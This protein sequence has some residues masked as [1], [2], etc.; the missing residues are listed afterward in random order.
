M[1]IY[2]RKYRWKVI[3]VL[4]ALL[5]VAA[6][7]IY[8]DNLAGKLAKEEKQK[9]AQIADV[10]HYIATATDI[11]DYG[12]FVELI[13]ANKTVPIISTDNDGNIMAW[14]N[15]D[16]VKATDKAYLNKKL[17]EMKNYAEP[18][19][20]EISE[21]M[22][23]YVYYKHSVLYTQLLYYPYVQ[24]IIIAAFLIVAY[25]LFNTTRK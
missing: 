24:L 4:A 7:L 14:L 20:L 2:E 12:F 23:Q 10:Y 18:I 9:V 25:T 22:Y 6:T 11:T 21:G 15:L 17:E 13:Q 1:N 5:I 8:T 16:S 3:L 19:K